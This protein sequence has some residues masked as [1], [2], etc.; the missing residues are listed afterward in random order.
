MPTAS[1]RSRCVAT[2]ILSLGLAVASTAQ[3]QAD[4]PSKPVT[5]VIP[6]PPAGSTDVLG[7][8]LA[9]S[10][11]KALQQSVVI[12]NV[13]G[14]GGTIGSAKVARATG[15]GYTLLF[16]NMAQASAP[17]LYARLPFDPLVDFEP[18][19]LVAEVPMILVARKTFPGDNLQA[20][21]AYARANPD[22][23]NFAHAGVGATSQLC[24]VL[25]KQ[26]TGVKW[27]SVPY[28]GTGPALNDLLGGQV[29]LI[30]D[31]PAS[32]LGHIRAG[33]IKPI[34][35]ATSARLK[36]L[37]AVPTMAESGLPG[38]QLA[39]WH[40]LYA[41]KGTPRPAIDKLAT[42]LQSALR[43][44]PLVDR[45]QEMSASIAP[46]EQATPDALRRHLRSDV[47]RWKTTLKAAGILPE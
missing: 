19:G 45:Y 14:A 8:L 33:A 22:K 18:V 27:T 20:V 26:A 2:L 13:G 16:N 1:L 39:V 29:D 38:F 42:A 41:P 23:L 7:R 32:T 47:D 25:L 44:A 40:G 35:V 15:D 17:A 28:K 10:M 3:A 34:A 5:V 36:I 31:Q 12:E 43:D 4:Y 24:E 37:P 11:G 46:P 30:C 6:F 9:Q 21:L